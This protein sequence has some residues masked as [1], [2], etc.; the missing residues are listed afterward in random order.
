NDLLVGLNGNVERKIVL[1]KEV[2]DHFP[3]RPERRI[4]SPVGVVPGDGEITLGRGGGV[5]GVARHDELTVRLQG[6]RVRDAGTALEGGHH[7][8]AR[9]ERII[10][11]AI[12]VKTSEGEAAGRHQ[13]IGDAGDAGY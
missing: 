2:N 12:R 11:A 1:P 8:A 13:A 7:L 3:A 9:A 5:V 10:E 6:E 4:Q